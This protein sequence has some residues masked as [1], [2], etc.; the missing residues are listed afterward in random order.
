MTCSRNLASLARRAVL[1]SFALLLALG[2]RRSQS[3]ALLHDANGDAHLDV[4]DVFYLINFLFAGGPA[5][6]PPEIT[7]LLPG[8]VPLVMVRIP[9]GTFQMGSPDSEGGRSPDEQLHQVTLTKDYYI[10]KYEVTQ[11]QW[12]AVMGGPLPVMECG[13]IYGIGESNPV[14]CVSWISIVSDFLPRLNAHL[15]G[16]G[17]PGAGLYRLPTEA[18]WERAARAETQ[19]RFPFEEACDEMLF[20][21]GCGPARRHLWWCG[22][23]GNQNHPVGQKDANAF[24]L[25]DM[26]GNL[27]E[28]VSDRYGPYPS[29]PQVDPT[30][31]ASGSNFV[32]R[33]GAWSATIRDCRSA[34]RKWV[35]PVATSYALGFRLARSR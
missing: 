11:S 33:G 30:G 13:W 16:T 8:N 32:F 29:T 24:G 25:H 2:P 21:C 7:V 34:T 19:T 10:G 9:S 35:S 17:Q 12:L 27:F 20:P 28:W 31:P 5:P 22:N 23:S 26:A 4:T 14:Y 1:F 3:Q 6:V 15:A 18:E